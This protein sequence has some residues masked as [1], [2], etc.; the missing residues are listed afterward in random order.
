[1]LKCPKYLEGVLWNVVTLLFTPVI[2]IIAVVFLG[3]AIDYTARLTIADSCI[4]KG[5]FTIDSITFT[6]HR[7]DFIPLHKGN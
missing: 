5:E 3:I 6:C 7:N 2:L 4:R 1:M